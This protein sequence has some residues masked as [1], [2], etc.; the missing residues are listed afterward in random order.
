MM[1]RFL[2]G[3]DPALRLSMSP[4]RHRRQAESRFTPWRQLIFAWPSVLAALLAIILVTGDQV[5]T[6]ATEADTQ[7]E[8]LALTATMP[9]WDAIRATAASIMKNPQAGT[10]PLIY[11]VDP[12]GRQMGLPDAASTLAMKKLPAALA[13]ELKATELAETARQLI[14]SLA[15][16]NLAK[17]AQAAADAQDQTAVEQL[18]R[19]ISDQRAWLVEAEEIPNLRSIVAAIPA[20]KSNGSTPG[21]AVDEALYRDYAASL[22]LRYPSIAGTSDSWLGLLETRGI[23]AW[24]DR[25]AAEPD[26]TPVDE[27]QAHS[28]AERYAAS[29]LRPLLRL[30]VAEQGSRLETWAAQRVYRNWLSINEW[31][32]AVRLSRGLARLC[33]SWQWTVH[34][35]QNHGEQKLIVTFPPLGERMA[36]GG[37]AEMVAVGDLIYL[38]WEV[39]GRVQEDSLLFS[40]EA[41]R[42]EG[43]F[44]NN[45]GGWGSVTGKRTAGCP[46][47]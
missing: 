20:L 30:S 11:F 14:R 12:L 26:K 6:A 8:P 24:H 40:K 42:L 18:A 28:L 27:Q 45:T 2:A 39:G 3:I 13:A 15:A 46:K 34:N 5:V 44:V 21:T 1:N 47:K 4:H 19:E 32:D 16:W 33:G 10:D 37:P 29:R 22:D 25:L 41:Q 9:Q 35:H 17:A 36:G 23:Q 31:K 43:S 7:A 38:R